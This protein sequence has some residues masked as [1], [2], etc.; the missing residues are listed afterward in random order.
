MVDKPISFLRYLHIFAEKERGQALSKS[1]DFLRFRSSAVFLLA[2]IHSLFMF[3]QYVGHR[4]MPTNVTKGGEERDETGDVKENRGKC[5]SRNIC[6]S[7]S[8]C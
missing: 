2:F 8:A 5:S 6:L 4:H 3:F 1:K 7:I